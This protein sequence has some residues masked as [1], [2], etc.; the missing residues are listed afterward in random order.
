MRV[1]GRFALSKAGHDKDNLYVIVNEEENYVYL[2]DG[3]YRL[4]DNPKKKKLK[5]IEIIE[6]IDNDLFEK[7]NNNIEVKNEEIKRSLKCYKKDID[8]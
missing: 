7:I 1:K 3:K 6:Y 8:K 4:T 5:H 2:S